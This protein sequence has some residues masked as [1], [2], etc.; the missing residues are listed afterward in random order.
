MF[1]S[2]FP[3][4]K[5]WA[6]FCCAHG[7]PEQMLRP[8]F[9]DCHYERLFC[10]EE[11]ALVGAHQAACQRRASCFAN[12]NRSLAPLAASGMTILRV[13]WHKKSPGRV[14]HSF[15]RLE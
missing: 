2:L 10:R 12:E 7:V 13:S 14:L 9:R 8:L 4:L 5:R 15:L 6:F 11:S 3:P 1:R